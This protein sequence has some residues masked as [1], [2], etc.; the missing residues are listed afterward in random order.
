MKKYVKRTLSLGM[1]G[2]LLFTG[3]GAKDEKSMTQLESA[4]YTTGTPAETIPEADGTESGS[5]EEIPN[6]AENESEPEDALKTDDYAKQTAES[7]EIL[8]DSYSSDAG[9]T[10]EQ[11]LAYTETADF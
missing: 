8:Q 4:E 10:G 1:A 6:T 3:C 7:E 5:Y 11:K 2:V 9:N